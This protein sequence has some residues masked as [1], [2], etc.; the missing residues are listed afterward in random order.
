MGKESQSWARQGSLIP[1]L[2]KDGSEL[3]YSFR[4]Q[5]LD[6]I[7][8]VT[9]CYDSLDSKGR[10]TWSQ[11]AHEEGLNSILQSSPVVVYDS[12]LAAD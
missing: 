7:K 10:E 5:N 4:A 9:R 6:W 3:K 2:T 11:Q 8:T 12:K 1:K